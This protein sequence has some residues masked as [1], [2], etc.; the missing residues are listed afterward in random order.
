[1]MPS[2]VNTLPATAANAG[3]A[4]SGVA[5][6]AAAEPGAFGR[7]L[8]R[9]TDSAAAQA[10][11]DTPRA[12]AQPDPK[13]ARGATPARA[14]RAPITRR[15]ADPGLPGVESAAGGDAS[16][17]ALI[18]TAEETSDPT[19]TAS[20]PT[21]LAAWMAGLLGTPEAAAGAVPTAPSAP[22]ST[23]TPGAP[24]HALASTEALP[25][26]GGAG[27]AALLPSGVDAVPGARTAGGG[28]AAAPPADSPVA[29]LAAAPAAPPEGV[30]P[31][32]LG[33]RLDTALAPDPRSSVATTSLAPSAMLSA[34]PPPVA[35]TPANATTPAADAL[36]P[37]PLADP[38]FAPAIGTQIA[39]FARN[40]I[41]HARLRLNPAEMG[42]IAVQLAMDG[43][44]VRVELLADVAATRQALEQSLPALA[45]ALRDAGFTLSGGGVFQQGR[46]GSQPGAARDGQA[47][48]QVAGT[49]AGSAGGAAPTAERAA[50][51]QGLVDL[52]A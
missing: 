43:Q 16:P 22:P 25:G 42:P 31:L 26:V 27:D 19:E 9:L 44:Q 38:S 13:A 3:T 14:D 21:D 32:H 49:A 30:L 8:Q 24:V 15:A 11:G 4:V 33:A 36:I 20:D 7:T 6:S 47:L 2:S 5:G 1:M 34:P 39:H 45:S 51:T 23:T 52:F 50:R 48:A 29:G 35:L 28:R 18:A 37:T 17:V 10:A 46:D 41:E 12:E 40:G